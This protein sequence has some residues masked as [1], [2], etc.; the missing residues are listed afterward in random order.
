MVARPQQDTSSNDPPV[1][2]PP[3]VQNPQPNPQM[4]FR[5]PAGSSIV[6]GVV[7]QPNVFNDLFKSG[8]TI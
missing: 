5:P 4:P 6:V 3:S 2:N 1:A 8:A 7:G